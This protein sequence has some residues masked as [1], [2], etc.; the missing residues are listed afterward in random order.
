MPGFP[1]LFEND[2][3]EAVNANSQLGADLSNLDSNLQSLN[4]VVFEPSP[5]N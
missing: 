4:G 1:Q 3:T 2:E 5:P